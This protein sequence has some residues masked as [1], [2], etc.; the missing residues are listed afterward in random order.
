M[1]NTA[2]H[3]EL[4]KFDNQYGVK[5]FKWDFDSVEDLEEFFIQK[6]IG[7][8]GMAGKATKAIG[9]VLLMWEK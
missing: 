5:V 6:L 8:P 3:Y 7:S 1:F 9:K 2:M 4:T